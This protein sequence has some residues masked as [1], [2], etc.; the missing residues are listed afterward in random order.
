MGAG[1]KNAGLPATLG[2]MREADRET[3]RPEFD[4]ADYARTHLRADVAPVSSTGVRDVLVFDEDEGARQLVELAIAARGHSVRS[5]SN[6]DQLH[7]SLAE[8]RPDLLVT[9]AELSTA[10]ARLFCKTLRDLVGELPIVL[11]ATRIG[12]DIDDAAR[13][14]RVV[15]CV[16]KDS[17]V[18]ALMDAITPFLRSAPER[19]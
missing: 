16:Y 19:S 15:C 4:L 13:D 12:R 5:A 1:G 14:A 10:S 6:F 18:D 9:D 11:F 17:G 2:G 3:V 7:A 8:R